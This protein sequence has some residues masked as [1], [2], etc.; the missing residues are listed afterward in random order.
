MEIRIR[1]QYKFYF[2]YSEHVN[3][4]WS[5]ITFSEHGGGVKQNGARISIELWDMRRKVDGSAY[6]RLPALF[7]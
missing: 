7:L 2:V 1:I 6:F 4:K 5:L 3:S